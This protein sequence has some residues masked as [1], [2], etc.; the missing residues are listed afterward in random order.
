MN[1]T[2]SLLASISATPEPDLRCQQFIY[3]ANFAH[4]KVWVV[5][6]DMLKREDWRNRLLGIKT[7]ILWTTDAVMELT[8]QLAKEQP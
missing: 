2:Q 7:P 4:E 1:H 3:R 8:E 5:T 6:K